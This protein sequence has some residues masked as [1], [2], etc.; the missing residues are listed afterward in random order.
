LIQKVAV[1]VVIFDLD[2]VLV[3][4]EPLWAAAKRELVADV[5]GHW[6]DNAPAAMLGMSGPEW[7]EYMRATLGVPLAAPAIG[8]RVVARMLD[9]IEESVP[10]MMGAQAAVRRVAER[11][12]IALASSA[13]RPVIEAVLEAIGLAPLFSAVVSSNEV[14]R[15]KP[16][17][18]VYR[19]AADKLGVEPADAV[20]VEDSGN[21]MLA[22]KAAGMAVIAIPNPSTGV[23][24]GTLAKA[25]VVLGSIEELTPAVVERVHARSSR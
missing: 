15:G 5:G 6:T 20:A 24:D 18:D 16:A 9:H 13:D 4:T 1:A 12:P 8:R 23:D 22:A 7:S 10:V 3:D 11:W 21:G 17:P 25:D 2:G 19:A 14:A